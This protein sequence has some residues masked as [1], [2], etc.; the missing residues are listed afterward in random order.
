MY[1]KKITDQAR[2]KLQKKSKRVIGSKAQ[3]QSF[4]AGSPQQRRPSTSTGVSKGSPSIAF[5]RKLVDV[6]IRNMKHKTTRSEST[7]WKQYTYK[8]VEN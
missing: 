5:E 6:Q 2:R 7:F 8:N 1:I 3:D 4:T